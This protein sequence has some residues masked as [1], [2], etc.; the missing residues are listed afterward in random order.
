MT[1]PDMAEGIGWGAILEESRTGQTW[2]LS[3][4]DGG[5]AVAVSHPW[6]QMGGGGCS[7]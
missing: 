1:S 6:V 4:L 7:A 5:L 3:S 2:S